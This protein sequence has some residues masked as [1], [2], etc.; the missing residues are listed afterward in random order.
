MAKASLKE[1][2]KK[3]KDIDLCMMTTVGPHGVVESRPMSNNGQVEYD[4]NSYFY[5]WED[6][7]LVKDLKKNKNVNLGFN[8]KKRLFV[9]VTGKAR[10]TKNKKE[11]EEHLT[12]G[13][14]RWFKKGPE[15]PGVVMVHVKAKRVKYWQDEEEG[16]F[17]QS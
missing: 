5:T 16:E 11:L 17:I 7:Q 1:I 9:S 6:S 3:L 2:S 4:G 13:L 8:G 15:T 10:L 12:D 14:D